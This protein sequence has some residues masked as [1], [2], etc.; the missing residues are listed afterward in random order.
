MEIQ[1]FGILD[2]M[3]GHSVGTSCLPGGGH[4]YIEEPGI[5]FPVITAISN[6]A[7]LGE[8]DIAYKSGNHGEKE[9]G[10]MFLP[11]ASPFKGLWKP[12]GL[13][14][15]DPWRRETWRMGKSINCNLGPNPVAHSVVGMN[16][17]SMQ[18]SCKAP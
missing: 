2:F 14:P 16:V 5:L 13:G 10:N 17:P 1:L 11:L 7:G 4:R 18:L 15:A 8:K 6:C 3:L 12:K 9:Y